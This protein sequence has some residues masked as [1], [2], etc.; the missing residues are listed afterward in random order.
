MNESSF[1]NLEDSKKGKDVEDIN[2]YNNIE[3]KNRISENI[4]MNLQKES[5]IHYRKNELKNSNYIQIDESKP[6]KPLFTE[7]MESG[8][9]FKVEEKLEVNNFHNQKYCSN[10]KEEGVNEIQE[11]QIRNRE[12]IK[13]NNNNARDPNSISLLNNEKINLDSDII[14]ERKQNESMYIYLVISFIRIT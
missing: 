5:N 1:K 6:Q 10:S 11:N 9:I 7:D 12:E 2:C 13:K 3:E 14:E 8:N 4:Y